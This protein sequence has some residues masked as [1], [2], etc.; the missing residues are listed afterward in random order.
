V[1]VDYDY[2][3]DYVFKKENKLMPLKELGKFIEKEQHLPNIKAENEFDK[4]EGLSLGEMN[5]K[6]LEKSSRIDD[7]H[8]STQKA[9]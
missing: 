1:K 8:A 3:P 4:K 5:L 9:K 6:L 7:L 2:I